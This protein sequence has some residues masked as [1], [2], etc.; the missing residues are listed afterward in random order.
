[1]LAVA[2]LARGL[3]ADAALGPAS[4]WPAS[5]TVVGLLGWPA[6]WPSVQ[7]NRWGPTR[8]HMAAGRG[9]VADC[10]SPPPPVSAGGRTLFPLYK[11]VMR[12]LPTRFRV[13]VP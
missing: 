5:P 4:R 10:P 7:G 1:L 6:A 2:W 13:R 11:L 9:R 3:A 8:A 12:R